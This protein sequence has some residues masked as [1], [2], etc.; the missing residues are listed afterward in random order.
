MGEILEGCVPLSGLAFRFQAGRAP[1]IDVG[2]AHARRA[3]WKEMSTDL[4][5]HS[6]RHLVAF[7]SSVTIGAAV[8]GRSS[9]GSIARELQRTGVYILTMDSAEGALW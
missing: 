3:L 7:D 6:R 2:E 5:N 9:S 1:H 8:K 4:S